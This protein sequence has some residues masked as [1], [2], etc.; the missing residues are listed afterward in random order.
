MVYTNKII[1][2]FIFNKNRKEYKK[3]GNSITKEKF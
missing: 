1:E 3:I 2:F